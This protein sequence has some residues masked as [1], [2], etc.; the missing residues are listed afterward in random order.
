MTVI[1]VSDDE[2]VRASFA[3]LGRNRAH[4]VECVPSDEL[5]ESVRRVAAD[6]GA[7]LYLDVGEMEGPLLKRRLTRLRNQCPYRFGVTDPH[8]R[9]TDV[10]ELFHGTAVD[11]V[12]PSLLESGFGA[13][14]LRR[15]ARSMPPGPD[16][17]GGGHVPEYQRHRVI[18]SGSDWSGVKD[19]N[20]YTFLMVYAGIDRPGD[21]SRKSSERAQ[22]WLRSRFR[23]MLE[24]TFADAGART[25]MATD[26][27][28]LLLL[29]FDGRRIRA[30]V[31]ALRLVL[32]RPIVIA[33]EYARVGDL[34]WRLALHLGNTTYE[35]GENT[36]TIVSESVNFLFHLGSRF[37]EHGGLAVTAACHSLLP[38]RL[39]SLLDRRTCFESV[40]VYS[41]RRRQ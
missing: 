41:L 30:F 36:A 12:G 6:P 24:R 28:V 27:E 5:T 25:W 9:I 34:S 20:V 35:S 33:E 2:V 32:N 40:P 16:D 15:V 4:T 8:G 39:R 18:P 21:L 13:A 26:D 11:Y 29:P 7:L 37:L 22:A 17:P 10:A 1:V 3:A 14:R 23:T 19:G 31:P 38:D